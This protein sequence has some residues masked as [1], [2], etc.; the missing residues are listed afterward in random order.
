MADPIPTFTYLV[1]KLA[2]DYPDL[3]FLHQVEPG[4]AGGWDIDAKTGEVRCDVVT[5]VCGADA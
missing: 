3:A 1:T 2:Q 4:V 5:S